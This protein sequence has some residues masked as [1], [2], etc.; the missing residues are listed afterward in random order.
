MVISLRLLLPES[1]TSDLERRVQVRVSEGR[2]TPR[3]LTRDV[4]CPAF[5]PYDH[6]NHRADGR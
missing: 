2:W 6:G 5:P 3:D 1:W 4:G